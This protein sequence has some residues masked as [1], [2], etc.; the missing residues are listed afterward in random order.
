MTQY[1]LL[2]LKMLYQFPGKAWFHYNVAFQK[3]AAAGLDTN[4]STY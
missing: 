1:K 2:I 3:D 4:F